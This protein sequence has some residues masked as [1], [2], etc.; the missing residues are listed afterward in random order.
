MELTLT[1]ARKVQAKAM[2]LKQRAMVLFIAVFE[3]KH[4]Y[5]PTNRDIAARFRIND[6]GSGVQYH[7]RPLRKVGVIESAPVSD[8]TADC[9]LRFS[10]ADGVLE[11]AR[12]PHCGGEL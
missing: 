10:V 1:D 4:G 5:G 2:T 12:C 6:Y 11:D 9:K 3:R 7:L 8:E